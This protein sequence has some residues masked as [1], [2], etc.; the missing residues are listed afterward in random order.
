MADEITDSE[1]NT[2]VGFIPCISRKFDEYL[3]AKQYALIQ[4][5]SDLT[6]HTEPTDIKILELAVKKM[7]KIN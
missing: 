2:V 7:R 1:F 6:I 4:F 5:C 3:F